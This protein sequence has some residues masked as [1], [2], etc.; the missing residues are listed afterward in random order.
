MIND[1]CN[2]YFRRKQLAEQDQNDILEAFK[3]VLRQR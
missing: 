1:A 3:K 2:A